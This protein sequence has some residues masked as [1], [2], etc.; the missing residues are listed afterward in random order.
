MYNNINKRY[1]VLIQFFKRYF[2]NSEKKL[3]LKVKKVHC[4]FDMHI[5]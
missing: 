3:K 2:Y 1:I 4:F 5:H